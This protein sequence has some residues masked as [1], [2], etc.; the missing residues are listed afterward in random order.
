MDL[1]EVLMLFIDNLLAY[2]AVIVTASFFFFFL[3]ENIHEQIT[4]DS[5][6]VFQIIIAQWLL[7]VI[8]FMVSVMG[9]STFYIL[10][11]KVSCKEFIFIIILFAIYYFLFPYLFILAKRTLN[12]SYNLQIRFSTLYFIGIAA[13]LFGYSVMSAFNEARKVKKENYYKGIIIIFSDSKI[14][15]NHDKYFV[16]MTKKYLFIYDSSDKS[17]NIYKM[18]EVNSIKFV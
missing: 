9:A 13:V 5:Y 11:R 16:G 15:S 12:N 3:H 4:D 1:Q 14:I 2:I 10:S 18:K 8:S 7:I 17:S 6:T